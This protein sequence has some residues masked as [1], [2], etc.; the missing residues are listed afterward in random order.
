MLRLEQAMRHVNDD[1][2]TYHLRRLLRARLRFNTFLILRFPR[3]GAP[4]GF[5]SWIPNTQL[6]TDYNAK[7]LNGTYQLDP[8]FRHAMSSQKGGMFR[9]SDI[10][11]DRFF[12]SEYY[13]KYYQE[14]LLSDEIGLIVP[15]SDGSKGHLSISRGAELGRF[16]LKERR[17]LMHFSPILIELVRQHCEYRI[18]IGTR[19][20]SGPSSLALPAQIRAHARDELQANLTNREAEITSLVL[21]GHSSASAA[22]VLGMSRQTAKV[23]RRNIYRKLQISSQAELFTRMAALF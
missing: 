20:E 8:F 19:D 12:M 1:S 10:A 17:C 4:E 11:P 7:Y 16:H 9:L 21:Q 18:S 14:T 2:F 23:H 6:H 15:L 5:H 13:V 22:L 3:S